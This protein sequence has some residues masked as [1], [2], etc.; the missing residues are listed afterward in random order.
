MSSYFI[1]NRFLDPNYLCVQ[2]DGVE[3]PS[4][5]IET[6][7]CD[8]IC[9]ILAR[10]SREEQ[11]SL[12]L[13]SRAWR[14]WVIERCD[15]SY[16]SE[17]ERLRHRVRHLYG[18]TGFEQFKRLMNELISGVSLRIENIP[19]PSDVVDIRRRLLD[20]NR[21]PL[22]EDVVRLQPYLRVRDNLVMW[23][24]LLGNKF[25]FPGG[26]YIED[27]W[28]YAYA[29]MESERVAKLKED[30]ESL[31]LAVHELFE[32]PSDLFLFSTL[33]RLRLH[34]NRFSAV[35][36]DIA[37]LSKLQILDLSNNFLTG[38]PPEMS[39]LT[40]LRVLDVAHN[41]LDMSPHEIIELCPSLQRLIISVPDGTV[42]PEDLAP[43]VQVV[44]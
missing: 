9:E 8:M 23:Q 19:T 39:K 38:L 13:T 1:R 4:G 5:D 17:I 10:R 3:E 42:I 32:F 37:R 30:A 25:W 12:Y 15:F 7:P 18:E 22:D 2:H 44:N 41:P 28:Q 40:E 31:D 16:G 34:G 27:Y 26:G 6:L 33:I 29:K 24:T 43:I 36:R 21:W 14:N 20:R 11:T 35:P